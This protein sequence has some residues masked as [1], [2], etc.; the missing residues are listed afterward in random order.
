[1]GL[2]GTASLRQNAYLRNSLGASLKEIAVPLQIFDKC[3]E[4]GHA[5]TY[6]I[7]KN[8]LMLVFEQELDI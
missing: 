6:M 2:E 1:M 8:D 5:C 4:R 7:I 3:K